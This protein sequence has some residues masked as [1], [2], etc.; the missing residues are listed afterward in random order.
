VT[1]PAPK[2][3]RPITDD[4]RVGHL[5]VTTGFWL[6][7]D[8]EL[9]PPEAVD[10]DLKRELRLWGEHYNLGGLTIGIRVHGAGGE[11]SEHEGTIGL[12]EDIERAPLRADVPVTG[13]RL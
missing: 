7:V 11:R 13:E 10:E 2:T 9:D 5:Y 8:L 4:P 12:T 1:R 6:Q 3:P